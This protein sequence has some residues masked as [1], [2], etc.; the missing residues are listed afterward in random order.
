MLVISGP[1]TK[2][3]VPVPFEFVAGTSCPPLRLA[4]NVW[5]AAASGPTA[6]VLP[7]TM[8]F[9]TRN[10]E[11][12]APAQKTP[13][14]WDNG[15]TQLRARL[16]AIGLPPLP[17]EGTV[18]HI[19]QHLDLYVDGKKVTVPAL[20]GI[21]ESGGQPFFAELH[22]HARA[23]WHQI[24]LLY[25]RLLDYTPSPVVELNRA[26]AVSFADGPERGLEVLDTISG[27]DECHLLHAT[28]ADLLRRLDRWAE[29][30]AAYRAALA[31]TT[32]DA[33]RRFLEGRLRQVEPEA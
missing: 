23:D 21:G 24:A 13:P 6:A 4:V 29:S 12:A 9:W 30:A 31:L 17:Q 11:P 28:R 15:G 25:E 22:T 32:N 16:K 7:A 3:P 26:V 20:I 8:V 5:L 27:L 10:L 2:V 1:S 14:P 19:H 33:E 18:I